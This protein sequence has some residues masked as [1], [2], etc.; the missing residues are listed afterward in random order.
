LDETTDYGDR[1]AR[2]LVQSRRYIDQTAEA[3]AAFQRTA[4]R[5]MGTPSRP[6]LRPE[7]VQ[8]LRVSRLARGKRGIDIDFDKFVWRDH[9]AR[10]LPFAAERLDKAYQHNEP[11]LS[12]GRAERNAALAYRGL[13]DE[14]NGLGRADPL[15]DGLPQAYKD[16]LCVD[17]ALIGAP[18]TPS[19]QAVRA[20]GP[21]GKRR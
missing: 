21:D 3:I 1:F 5:A 18:A 6:D 16:F 8:S 12:I 10:H 7:V 2:D 17:R 13:Q 4:V 20:E 11:S 14:G 15:A 19:N 9:I